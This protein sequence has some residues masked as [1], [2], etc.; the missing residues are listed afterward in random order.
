MSQNLQDWLTDIGLGRHVA[1]LTDNGI[2]LDILP[3]LN[4]SDLKE[5]GLSLG[6]RKRLLKAIAGLAP[7]GRERV[8]EQP[9][10]SAQTDKP[11]TA[12]AERRSITVMFVDLV[13]STPMS[14]KL[15]PEDMREVL[16]AFHERCATAIEGEDGHIARYMGDGVLVYFGYPHAHED[17]AARAVRAA[18]GVIGGVATSNNDLERRFGVRLQVRIGIHTGLVVV[19]D[20]GAGST[21]DREAIVGET[22]NIAARLQGEAEPDTVVISAT[23][24]RLVEGLFSFEDVGSRALKGVSSLI[25]LFRVIAPAETSDRFAARAGRGLTPLIGRTA[26]LDM[27]RQ[28]WEQARDGEMRCVLVVGEAGIGKSRMVHAFRER[29]ADQPHQIISWHCSSYHASSAFF[30]IVSWLCRSLGIDP[31]GEREDGA[32]RLAE[33]LASLQIAD[34]DVLSALVSFLGLS[35]EKPVIQ[36]PALTYRRRVLDALSTVIRAMAHRQPLFMIVEDAHWVDPST[37][38][39]LHELQERLGDARLLLLVTARPEFRP[40]WNYPQFVQVNV[41]RLSRRERQSMIEQLTGGK[42][43][44]DFVMEQIVA[45]TDGVPLFVEEL[46]KT[47]LEGNSWRDTGSHFELE[48]PFQGIAIPDSLQ[49]SL[50]ARL[51]RLDSLTREIAQLGATIGREFHRA[52]LSTVAGHPDEALDKAFDQLVTAEIIQ[53]ALGGRAFTFRHALI[54]DAAYQSLLLARRRQYH[55]TIGRALLAEFADIAAAQPELVAQHLTSADEVEPALDAW[56]HAAQSAMK[57][58]AYAEARVHVGRGLELVRRVASDAERARRAVPFLL[59]RGRTEIKETRIKAQPTLLRAATLAREA[60][61]AHEFAEA[62]MA[63]RQVEQFGFSTNPMAMELLREALDDTRIVDPVLRC[64]LLAQLAT[65]CHF[66]GDIERCQALSTE[67]RTEAE[68]LGDSASLYQA[69]GNQL[70]SSGPPLA[71]DFGQRRSAL[72]HYHRLS[73]E[74]DD[75]FEAIYASSHVRSQLLELGDIDGF[76][77]AERRVVELART[78]QAPNDHWMSL[79]AQVMSAT[80]AGDYPLAETKASEALS[81]VD[82]ATSGPYLGIY[83]MQMFTIRRE[84][85]RLGEVAPLVKRFVSENPEESI[86]RPGLMLIASD[87]GFHVQ[88]RK[89]FEAFAAADF[90]LPE[91][92]KRGLTLAYF[93]EVCAALGDAERAERLIELLAPYRDIVLVIPPSTVCG[94]AARHYLGM[95]SATARDWPAAED[96]FRRALELNERIKAWPRLAWTRLEYARMLLARGQKGD[97]VLASELRRMAVAAAERMGMGLLLQRNA[98]MEGRP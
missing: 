4:E 81:I 89:H 64:R 51:D 71:Q 93:A 16:R 18:L 43:L 44:P 73:M 17:D 61:L 3:E 52:L 31:Q 10:T 40:E 83:G 60:G 59:I 58:G 77:E 85:G 55:A 34:P 68:R 15:D 8:V 13:G 84:Q 92:V 53:P 97:S 90:E 14:E 91:D 96:H 32:T 70:M 1:T 63:M 79:L 78:T 54:Q 95:L 50:L 80:L 57:R 25:R 5:L 39:L 65:A 62:A 46:T 20:V 72:V 29:L 9:A 7:E 49:G 74:N 33:A 30:P 12:T 88:A 75:P 28:R 11:A 47:V 23:T 69:L 45:R 41:D 24:R 87:L 21:R 67:A 19:G 86:W 82:E 37:L 98:A 36:E 26:E 42:A 6:D 56:L 76:H 66:R 35:G 22:P 2:D 94:G 38:D 48:G 27:L